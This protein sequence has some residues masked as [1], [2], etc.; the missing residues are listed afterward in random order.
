M[1]NPIAWERDVEMLFFSTE[2]QLHETTLGRINDD[3]ILSFAYNIPL[4]NLHDSSLPQ[5]LW[6]TS[7]F[8]AFFKVFKFPEIYM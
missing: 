4:S 6:V 3:R 2:K 5:T 7:A 8:K 1:G